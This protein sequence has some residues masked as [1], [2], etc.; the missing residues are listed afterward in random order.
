MPGPIEATPGPIEALSLLASF[1]NGGPKDQRTQGSHICSRFLFLVS[2]VF[3]VT[4]SMYHGPN[5]N[6]IPHIK[7]PKQDP[8][9]IEAPIGAPRL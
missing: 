8:E 9:V 3:M 7:T 5:M 4:F 6:R 2:K 1:L